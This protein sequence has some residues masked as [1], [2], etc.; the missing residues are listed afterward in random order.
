[1]NWNEW[2][3]LLVVASSLIPGIIIFALSEERVVT[4]TVLNMTGAISKLILVGWMIWA[5]L[6]GQSFETRLLLVGELVL[7][8]GPLAL[9]FV[10]L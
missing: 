9:I 7:R 10:S 2:V 6:N 3:P 4:R 8:A 5:V 1:M